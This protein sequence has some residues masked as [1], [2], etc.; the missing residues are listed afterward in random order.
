MHAKGFHYVGDWHTHP[1]PFPVPSDR[2]LDSISECM[3][4]SRHDLSAFIMIIVGTAELPKALHV[5]V[6]DGTYHMCLTAVTSART[7]PKAESA[8]DKKSKKHRRGL[9]R[10]VLA[11]WSEAW[12]L[13]LWA[14]TE[15][16]GVSSVSKW[17]AITLLCS[18]AI[19]PPPELSPEDPRA[20]MR[21]AIAPRYLPIPR[22]TG[23]PHRPSSSDGHTS[24]FVSSNPIGLR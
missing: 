18:T 8:A 10:L 1:D 20:S 2:D 24:I 15:F 13:A 23:M 16:V 4:R 21:S 6:H 5:S 11:R 19:C 17:F 9:S 14:I 3:K 12:Y 7:I 22:T